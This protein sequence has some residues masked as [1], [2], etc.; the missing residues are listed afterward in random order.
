MKHV[1]PLFLFILIISLAACEAQPASVQPTQKPAGTI[2]VF[3]AVSLTEAFNKLGQNYEQAHPGVKVAFNFAGSQQLA[4]Q[5]A[6][7]APA[8]VFASAD[9]QQMDAIVA[10]GQIASDAAQTLV[11]NQLTVVIPA[12]NPGK[13]TQVKDLAKPGLKIVLAAKEVPAGMYALNF[14]DLTVKNPDYGPSFKDSVLKNVVSYE[15]NVRAVLNKV[16]LGE[17]DAGIVYET[18]AR[19]E[20]NKVFTLKI[21]PEFTVEAIYYIAPVK[22]SAA[23]SQAQGFID[24][25]LSSDGQDLLAS[26]GFHPIR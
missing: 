23:A 3:A 14:L 4:Q 11:A 13:I 5:I 26:Y 6:Q 19:S 22:N 17:A 25:L 12:A 24:Y 16:A 2:S 18:D 10:N 8:D 1:S 20:P 21:P 15:E 7:G 9:K